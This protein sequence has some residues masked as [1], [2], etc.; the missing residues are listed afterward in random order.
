M[1]KMQSLIETIIQEEFQSIL[2]EKIRSETF[3][4][5]V[6]KSLPTQ[7]EKLDYAKKSLQLVSNEQDGTSR[8]VFLLS[9]TKVLKLAKVDNL[10]AGIA[11]NK[12]EQKHAALYPNLV[13]KVFEVAEDGSWATQ[14]L[15]KQF[16]DESQFANVSGFMFGVLKSVV[17]EMV[18]NKLSF[19]QVVA[20]SQRFKQVFAEMKKFQQWSAFQEFMKAINSGDDSF[21][22][23]DVIVIKH[24]GKTTDGRA[25]LLDHG[26]TLGVLKQFYPEKFGGG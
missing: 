11:Q 10:Q 15:V 18:Q 20:K 9:S 2:K 7:Q 5:N 22:P 24:W 23:L 25:V 17:V 21:A 1:S 14:E 4:W 8:V 13:T 6:F 12:M 3:Q 26:T 19:Q 16:S